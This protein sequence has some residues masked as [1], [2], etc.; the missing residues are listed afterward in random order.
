MEARYRRLT[1]RLA[2]LGPILVGTITPR[3][4]EKDDPDKPGKK[5][6]YGPYYQWTFKQEGKTVT[7]NLAAGQAKVYQQ[8]IDNQRKMEQIIEEMRTLS[9]AILEETT[10][11]VVKRKSRK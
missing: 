1:A 2:R 11:G 8:A 5:K 7:Q 3:V 6:T 4:I 10:E 9:L